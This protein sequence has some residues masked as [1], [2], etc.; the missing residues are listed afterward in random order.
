M[1]EFSAAIQSVKVLGDILK[2]AHELKDSTALIAA[3]NEVQCKLAVAYEAVCNA[4]EKRRALEQ[5]AADLEK[6]L[7]E[8]KDWKAD[9][10]KYQL[11][12]ICSGVFAFATKPGME[13]GEPPHKICAA[14]Y[15]KRQKSYL[16]LD[17]ADGRGTHYKCCLCGTVIIDHSQKPPRRSVDMSGVFQR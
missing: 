12:E 14:C 5:Q 7:N 17:G 13:N 10:E 11:T 3:V 2:S 4:L 16:Q 6:E 15:G 9:A 8:I 1:I